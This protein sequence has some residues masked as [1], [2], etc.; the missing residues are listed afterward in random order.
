[1]CMTKMG[2]IIE[3]KKGI[4]LVRFGNRTSKINVSLIKNVKMNDKILCSGDVAI[5]RVEDED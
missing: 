2:K 4:A 3:I 1:M 5:E